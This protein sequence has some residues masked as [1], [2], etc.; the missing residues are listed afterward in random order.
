MATKQNTNTT[1]NTTK[2]STAKSKK[3]NKTTKTMEK[4]MTQGKAQYDKLTK[5]IS[6]NGRESFESYYKSY[7]IMIKGFEDISKTQA[8]FFKELTEKQSKLLKESLSVRTLD[9]LSNMQN[10]AAQSTFDD[11]MEIATK[12]SEQYFKLMNE[13]F[14]PIN[15][16]VS[17]SIKKASENIAA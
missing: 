2:A 7:G 6:D 11:L 1:T 13:A 9:E 8:N 10:K 3:I 17:N 15:Q 12:T 16:Q 4:A 5:E 14:E